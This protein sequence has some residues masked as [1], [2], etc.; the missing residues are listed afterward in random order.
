MKY[1][2]L[3][4]IEDNHISCMQEIKKYLSSNK[5]DLVAIT[6]YLLN[7]NSNPYHFLDKKWAD[8]IHSSAGFL[9]FIQTLEKAIYY[10]KEICFPIIDGVPKIVFQN[11][12]NFNLKEYVDP[13]K[14]NEEDKQIYF[15]S[16]LQE[17]IYE[18]SCHQFQI[19]KEYF[20]HHA[21]MYGLDKA[22]EEFKDNE[23]YDTSWIQE[24][25]HEN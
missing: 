21:Q 14:D 13:N 18:H 22:I 23:N 16:N 6:T 2:L 3:Q 20:F 24:Y 7:T 5:K 8:Q 25:K 1:N 12:S 15:L 10:S 4:K 19:T 11:K 9:N 17:F